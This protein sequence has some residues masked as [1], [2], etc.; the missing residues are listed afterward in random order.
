ML[1]F[2]LAGGG[3][4]SGQHTH[5]PCRVPRASQPG[6]VVAK[7][8]VPTSK[9]PIYKY[10][11]ETFLNVL[12]HKRW[13]LEFLR[14]KLASFQAEIR[15]SEVPKLV[16]LLGLELCIMAIGGKFTPTPQSK[17]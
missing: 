13:A 14:L 7:E 16:D 2:S 8:E 6:S 10:W 15:T 1:E 12:F 17:K 9:S 4:E 11:R 3:G 5:F